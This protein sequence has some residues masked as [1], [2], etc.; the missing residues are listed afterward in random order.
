DAYSPWQ[1][2][3]QQAQAR[4]DEALCFA[5][6]RTQA[7]SEQ[8]VRDTNELASGMVDPQALYAELERRHPT[9]WREDLGPQLAQ[10]AL[11]RGEDVLPYLLQ[12][13]LEI[14]SARR[15]SGYQQMAELSRRLGWLELW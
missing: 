1:R 14:W 11:R 5:L 15:R 3:V 4:G 6:Y 7:P 2:L 12:H 13:A 9:R 8:W 10:L